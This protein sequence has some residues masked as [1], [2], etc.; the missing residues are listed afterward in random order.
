MTGELLT[1]VVLETT[2]LVGWLGWLSKTLIAI[3]LDVV[4]RSARQ[5]TTLE[6]HER[7]ITDNEAAIR[8]IKES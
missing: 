2:I 7:R 8:Q 4:G 6:D 3:K 1:L 5:D